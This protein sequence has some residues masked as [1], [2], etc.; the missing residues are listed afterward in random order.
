MNLKVKPTHG[1]GKLWWLVKLL[2]I[3][4]GGCG[5]FSQAQACSPFI[6]NLNAPTEVET[7]ASL[8]IGSV[9]A[10]INM[11]FPR[12]DAS[13]GGCNSS[14][15]FYSTGTHALSGN[16]AANGKLYA[17]TIQ[18]LSYRA[19]YDTGRAETKNFWPVSWY[20]PIGGSILNAGTITVE[21]VKTG[22]LSGGGTLGPQPIGAWY[23]QG[24][25]FVQFTLSTPVI[26][27][28]TDPACTVTQ[29][30]IAVNLD[31]T[32]T[33]QLTTMGNTSKDKAFSIPLNCTSA[34]NISLSF[35]GDIADANNAVFSNLSGSANANSV[36]VQILKD[37]SPV[38]TTAGSYLNLGAINGSVSV[39]LTARYYALTDNADVGAV[40]AIAYATIMYN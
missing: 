27:I 29:S 26:I 20:A 11:T 28:P 19:K 21:F 25:P 37:N 35:S 38:P 18:G 14:I 9:V 39:P 34:S 13:S 24:I 16:G 15:P 31:D 5:L 3:S 23:V 40:S 12:T 22:S 4:I 36:G 33:S 6:I 10:T 17:T 2:L 1:Q 8:P 30:A 7:N 32:N